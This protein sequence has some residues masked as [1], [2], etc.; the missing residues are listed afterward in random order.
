MEATPQTIATAFAEHERERGLGRINVG[1]AIA[2]FMLPLGAV[3]DAY[4]YSNQ[5]ETFLRWRIGF[6]LAMVPIWLIGKTPPGR[7]FYQ[8]I[9]VLLALIPAGCMALIVHLS[10][11][12]SVGA[13]RGADSPYYAGLNLVLL[14]IGLILQWNLRQ[15]LWAVGSVLV[16]YALAVWPEWTNKN[17][18]PVLLNNSWFLLLTGIIVVIG[19]HLHTK[20][21]RTEFESGY[22][23]EASRR[24]LE[25]TNSKLGESNRQLEESNQRLTEL[26]RLKGQFFANIS[27]ELRTPLTL[28]LAPLET[29]RERWG[30]NGDAGSRE[31]LDTMQANAMRLLKLIND[32]LDLVR[33]EVGRLTLHQQPVRLEN[34]MRG[35]ASSI[36]R[37]AEDRGLQLTCDIRPEVD[38]IRADPDKL[39]KIFLNLLFNAVKFTPAGGSIQVRA[40]REG[41]EAV[42]AVKDTG[43]GIAAENLPNL[44]HRFWQADTSSQRKYQGAGIGLA[45]VKELAVAHGGSVAAESSLGHGTTITV[46]LPLCDP[47]LPLAP[48]ATV[49]TG[50]GAD[51][52]A[53]MDTEFRTRQ[54]PWLASLYRRAELHAS[55]TPLRDT[56]RPWMPQ[57]ASTRPKLLV[58][59]DEPDMLRFLKSQLEE[60]YEVAEATDGDQAATFAA[61]LLPDVILC[62]M[63][64]PEKDGL[65]VCRLLRAQTSTRAIPFLMIT[66][67]ADD[68]TKLLALTAGVSDF[69]AKPFSSAELR[70][71]LKNLVD[72]HR[73]QKELGRQNQ[74]LKATLDELKETEL[75]LVQAEKLASL[76]RMSAGIIHEVNNPLNFA[77]TGLFMLAQQSHSLPEGE[78]KN[79]DETVNDIREGLTRVSTIVSDL[80]GFTHP[81]GGQMDDVKLHAAMESALR[82]MAAE[83]RN[84]VEIKNDIPPDLSVPAI[85]PRLIQVFVNLLQNSLDALKTKP[86]SDEPPTIRLS[87][88]MRGKTT[89]LSVRDN[90][91]GIPAHHLGKVFDPFFTTKEVGQGTGLGLSICYRILKEMGARIS[92]QSEAGKFC[93]FFL[94]FNEGLRETSHVPQDPFTTDA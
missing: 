37:F 19:N 58:A 46:R 7:R 44:F 9:G 2:C 80:R 40:T 75:Q 87:V 78:R 26:D 39:E 56:L 55:L 94:E 22:K 15:S 69:L 4:V 91:P 63:M 88:S 42:I 5:F 86:A 66:A 92:V 33:L 1:F 25:L 52:L 83:W 49:G 30:P 41:G 48:T 68:E 14:A 90:G 53:V 32:L 12:P 74:K 81:Q 17:M 70:L 79:F 62:D 28:L 67:R 50:P 64:L 60:D 59:D 16:M 11:D 18:H 73:M 61:Q 47:P 93:E 27:H 38:Y 82:F 43:V 54:D 24:E 10:D 29:I 76:G 72:T 84:Q 23:L 35:M 36:Q 89:V 71:R 57:R 20:L 8:V 13:H 51:E 34:F 21:R 31:L 3:V 65:E 6:A 77:Q 85:R 45:L